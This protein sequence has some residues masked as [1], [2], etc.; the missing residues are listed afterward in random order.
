MVENSLKKSQFLA[1]KF[2]LADVYAMSILKKTKN[3]KP[4]LEWLKRCD[5]ALKQ[6][7][8]L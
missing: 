5:L 2:S 3:N 1:K 4:I 8:N 6:G 7:K